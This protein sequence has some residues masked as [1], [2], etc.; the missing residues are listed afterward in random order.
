MVRVP[1]CAFHNIYFLQCLSVILKCTIA[2][3]L[4]KYMKK[5]IIL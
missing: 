5:G 2:K 3:K 4:Y 1:V